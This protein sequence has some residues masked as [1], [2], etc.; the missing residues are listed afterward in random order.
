MADIL[1]LADQEFKITMINML[2]KKCAKQKKRWL[3]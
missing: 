2:M 3:M 1:E